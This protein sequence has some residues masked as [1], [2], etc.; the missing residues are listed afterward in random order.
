MNEPGKSDRPIVPGNPANEGHCT[1]ARPKERGEGRGLAKENLIQ[2]NSPRTQSRA[3][4]QSSL[5]RIRQA[6]RRDKG[7]KF[8]SLWHHVYDI[9][10]L[11]EAYLS[12]KRQAAPGVDGQTWQEYGK[13]LEGNLQN[14]SGRLARGAYHAKAVKRAYVPKLDGKQRPIGIP[15]LE[16]KLVQRST[17]EVLNAVYETDFR[18]FSYGF[19]P[20]RKCHDALDALYVGIQA[21]KVS[22][23]LDADIRGFFD[24]LNHEWLIKFVEHRIADQRLVRHIKKW[25]NA[26]VLEDGEHTEQEEGTP[27]GG[28]IS[29][30][31]AN[32]YLHYVFDLWADQWR[33]RQAR[34]DVIIVRY[35]DD[36]VGGFQH[37]TDAQRFLVDLRERFAK[38]N[39]ELHAEKTRVIEFGRFA[40]S[41]RQRRGQGKP[42][43]FNFL[44]FTHICGKD[45]KG[46]FK[47][48][49]HTIAR[50]MQ[51][52]L[53]TIAQELRW[54]IYRK[55]HEVGQWLASVVRGHHLYYGVPDNY[56]A[57][58]AF[59][60]GVYE[61]WRRALS[62]RSQKAHITFAR[63]NRLRE[64]WLPR[65]RIHH[66]YPSERL[67]VIIQGKSPVR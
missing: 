6:A 35:A 15:T 53:A 45:R 26:G 52:K 24:A 61:H 56:F 8:T 59:S 29:P 38:F 3:R 39:L 34:G 50:R 11:R 36:F 1:T 16:D 5:D 65:P 55:V 66:P 57:L 49:R 48:V 32:I 18:G 19:R 67:R 33:K 58:A 13:E 25:L 10:R 62:R 7:L 51:A 60:R 12:L 42:E 28:S 64:R 46:K 9:D 27:Q 14:L 30:L 2:C 41:N 17:V 4:L 63:M 22:W 54:R 21:R 40:A 20:G 47:L 31:L 37:Q 44:G 23:V 43:T